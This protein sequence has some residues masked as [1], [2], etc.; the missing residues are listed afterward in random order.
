[1]KC[2][3]CDSE[4]VTCVD[5]AYGDM[6][7]C[8]THSTSIVQIQVE[9]KDGDPCGKCG[10]PSDIVTVVLDVP[11]GTAAEVHTC[12]QHVTDV[13]DAITEVLA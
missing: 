1:M 11:G 12:N 5:T 13:E 7:V 3:V 4:A 10:A 9:V 2:E 8:K 6:H